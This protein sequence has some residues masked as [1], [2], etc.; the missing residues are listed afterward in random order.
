MESTQRDHLGSNEESN[1]LGLN[2][3]QESN[4][5]DEIVNENFS[6]QQSSLFDN[7]EFN[8]IGGND[9]NFNDVL[10]VI[11]KGIDKDRDNNELN[12]IEKGK[13]PEFIVDENVSNNTDGSKFV[14]NNRT[15][16]SERSNG[17]S[18]EGSNQTQTR[19]R[20]NILKQFLPSSWRDNDSSDVV[21][22]VFH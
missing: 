21:K 17:A 4:E 1:N 22:V 8:R 11:N 3:L 5:K 10:E 13:N 14:Q 19:K 18:A 15:Q 2:F 7:G 6:N 12:N 20:L 9:L 16:S